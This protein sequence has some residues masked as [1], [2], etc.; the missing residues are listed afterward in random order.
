MLIWQGK[1][2]IVM[3]P[4][5]ITGILV[6]TF[7][8]TIGNGELNP[9][10]YGLACLIGGIVGAVGLYF[11]DAWMEKRNPP[12]TLVDPNTGQQV[13]FK[14]NDKFFFIPIKFFPYLF[15]LNA[16]FGVFL[17]LFGDNFDWS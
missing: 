14:R 17:L 9:T 3:V 16:V 5:I 11:F 13:Q 7:E 12:Q 1:G 2:I 10:V 15:A 8:Q 4:V 6:M